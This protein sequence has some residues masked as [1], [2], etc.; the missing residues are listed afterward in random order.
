MSRTSD[1][2]RAV[3]RELQRKI[4]L[5]MDFVSFGARPSGTGL[6]KAQINRSQRVYRMVRR[7]FAKGYT[8]TG[9]GVFLGQR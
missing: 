8:A 9:K 3:I 1:S 7:A 6:T 5:L 4:E 2:D